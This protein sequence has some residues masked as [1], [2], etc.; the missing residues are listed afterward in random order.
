MNLLRRFRMYLSERFPLGPYALLV[1]AFTLSAYSVV[2]ALNHVH[3]PLKLD[4]GSM[5]GFLTL[6]LI[7]LHLRIFDEFKDFET[8]RLYHPER[9]IPR[10]LVSL[11]EMRALGAVVIGAEIVLNLSLGLETFLYYFSVLL[12]SLLMFKEFFVG[13][14]LRRD[15]FVY[16][17]THTPVMILL[18]FYACN[19][20]VIRNGPSLESAIG[21]YLGICFF[22]GLA[23]EIARKVSAP[24]DEREGIETYSQ[25][26]GT[27]RVVIILI[28]LLVATTVCALMLGWVLH[29]SVYYIT[30][31][32]LIFVLTSVGVWRFRRAPTRENATGVGLY[33]SLYTL[34]VYGLI[35]I[36]NLLVR[37]IALGW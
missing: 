26:F 37:G 15:R 10:G 9:P 21:F 17:L 5:A 25:Y 30:G 8:D 12:Y 29:F 3:K 28:G 2:S 1:L 7:F 27:A 4:W 35:V 32:V 34:A 33:A 19:V 23:F 13:N 20:Y 24:E 6:F 14:W 18:G 36:E 22:T 31:A 16:A 11:G